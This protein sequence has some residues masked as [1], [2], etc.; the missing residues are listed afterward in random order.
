MIETSV[1]ISDEEALSRF[2]R[3]I[4]LR[5]LPGRAIVWF[6]PYRRAEG[7]IEIPEDSWPD[8]AEGVIIHDNT[9]HE[10]GRGVMV[11]VSR[12]KGD[13]KYFKVG[14]HRFCNIGEDGLLFVDLK[15]SP[16]EEE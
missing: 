9:I 1:F 14:E 11:A 10:L 5:A 15:F 3:H 6:L 8:S 7:V 12:M 2:P 16:E 13:G 4:H